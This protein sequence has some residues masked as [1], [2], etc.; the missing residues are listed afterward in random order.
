MAS[1]FFIGEYSILSYKIFPF[2]VHNI[3]KVTTMKNKISLTVNII[4]LL[5][6]LVLVAR[7]QKSRQPELADK[8]VT[9]LVLTV[10]LVNNPELIEKYKTYHSPQGVWPEVTHAA[11]VSGYESI[12]I[13]N[14]GSRLV[15]VLRYPN[16]IDKAKMDSLYANSS[17]RIK[18]WGEL[19]NSYMESVKGAP[20]GS[21]WIEME[22]IYE[23]VRS[24]Q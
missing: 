2:T 20:A 6:I 8:N 5:T 21:K 16:D 24:A 11:E 17:D 9:Q 7:N 23:Y 13:Y 15:M 22:P 10:D 4:L 19:M 1:G 3:K 14:F 12:Q 18:E